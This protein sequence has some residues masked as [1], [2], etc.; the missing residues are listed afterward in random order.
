GPPQMRQ[1]QA[2]SAV[3]GRGGCRRLRRGRRAGHR[4]CR[5]RPVGHLVRP[6]PHGEPG[7]G[8]GRRRSRGKDQTGQGRHRSEPAPGAAL[9]GPGGTDAADPRQGTDHRPAGGGRTCPCPAAMG[10]AVDRRPRTGRQ[11]MTG[12]DR[13]DRPPPRPRTPRD[14]AHR[15]MRGMPGHAFPLAPPQALPD[16]WPRRLLRL[17]AEP[18]RPPSRRRRRPSDRG[19]TGARRELA[20][21]LRPRGVRVMP[22]DETRPGAAPVP[23][24]PEGSVPFETPD[25]YGA[26]PRLSDGQ[27]ARLAQ[28]GRRRAVDAGEVLIREGER[29]ETFYVVLSGA[30]AILEDYG[31]PGERLL[32]VHGPGR[33]IGELGLLNGQVAFYTAVVRDPGEIL[34][35]SMDQLRDL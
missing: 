24:E 15:G 19:V 27:L 20:V 35:L 9:R 12:H 16:L 6:L 3:D 7:A 26:Y 22:G 5:G 18:A 21:V 33:F 11:R 14:P 34:A 2:A 1:L 29:C 30:L 4:S 17:L 32:R 10:G 8:E 31:T 28:R 13:T 23:G 25:I